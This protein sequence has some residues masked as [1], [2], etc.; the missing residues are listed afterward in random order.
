[1][2]RTEERMFSR[3]R[4]WCQEISRTRGQPCRE[5][6]STKERTRRFSGLPRTT[7]WQRE[8]RLFRDR[9]VAG[10]FAVPIGGLLLILQIH[11]RKSEAEAIHHFVREEMIVQIEMA[12][13]R[14]GRGGEEVGGAVIGERA[15]GQVE[16]LEAGKGGTAGESAGEF[17]GDLGIAQ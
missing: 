12:E 3:E 17:V 8:R 6:A 7:S 11:G 16:N 10:R 9:D 14:D 1:G 15:H 2:P 5:A 4:R 13:L